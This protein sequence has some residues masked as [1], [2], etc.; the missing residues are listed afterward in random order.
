MSRGDVY[1]GDGTM[2]ETYGST[3]HPGFAGQGE[4]FTLKDGTQYEVE[5]TGCRWGIQIT[6]M[7][8]ERFER[9]LGFLRNAVI[10]RPGHGADAHLPYAEI[11]RMEVGKD[12]TARPT[13]SFYLNVMYKRAG[14]VDTGQDRADGRRQALSTVLGI[15]LRWREP[16]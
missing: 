4:R 15:V 10:V 9:L 8:S 14:E 13:F 11:S 3:T 1:K 7:P 12:S 6:A 16:N 2:S 5:N